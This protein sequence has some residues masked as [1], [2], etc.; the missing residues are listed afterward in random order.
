[1]ITNVRVLEDDGVELVAETYFHLY[2][3]R[4]KSEV[5]SWVGRRVDKLRRVEDRLRIAD[6]VIY[7]DQTL[8]LS[9]NLSNLF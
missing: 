4:L 2:R 6:R 8:L 3:T 9:R 1:M 5:D 7:L